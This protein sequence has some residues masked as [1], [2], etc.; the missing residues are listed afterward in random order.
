MAFEYSP[1]PYAEGALE[2]HHSA[3]FGGFS[4]RNG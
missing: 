4:A 3:V 1:L 2:P